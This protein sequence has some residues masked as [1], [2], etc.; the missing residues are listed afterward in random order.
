MATH[1]A[2]S[3]IGRA[4]KRTEDLRF[5]TGNGQYVDDIV[6]DGMVHAFILRSP[7]AHARMLAVDTA[8]AAAS[9]GVLAVLTGTDQAADEHQPVAPGRAGERVYR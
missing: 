5:L 2:S 4:R 9:P 8:N 3:D 7:H 6:L 1:D